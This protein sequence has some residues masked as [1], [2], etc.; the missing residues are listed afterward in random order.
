MDMFMALAEPT[1]RSIVEMLA[2][3]NR[4]SASDI[5]SRFPSSGPAISQHLKVLRDTRVVIV[6]KD[7]QKRIY[8]IN[9]HSIDQIELWI[10][11]IRQQWE[12]RFD[13]LDGLLAD[14]M[15]RI[16]K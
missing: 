8:R 1:R 7:A 6:E 15:S 2:S 9:P 5:Y 14:E 11:N 12:Q 4:L 13:A 3:G 16:K 10:H